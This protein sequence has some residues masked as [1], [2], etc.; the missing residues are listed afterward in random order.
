MWF[1][2][3]PQCELKRTLSLGGDEAEGSADGGVNDV[4]LRVPGVDVILLARNPVDLK[5]SLVAVGV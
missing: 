2:Q 1:G 3:V 4:L 5:I